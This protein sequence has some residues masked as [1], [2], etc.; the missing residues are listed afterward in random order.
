M[1]FEKVLLTLV[2]WKSHGT[3]YKFC[4]KK[5]QLINWRARGPQ[6]QLLRWSQRTIPLSSLSISLSPLFLPSSSLHPTVVAI[7]CTRVCVWVCINPVLITFSD[8]LTLAW[9][10]PDEACLSFHYSSHHFCMWNIIFLFFNTG[11]QESA[12]VYCH[13]YRGILRQLLYVMHVNITAHFPFSI[14]CCQ[15]VM[16]K[17]FV[18]L[19]SHLRSW[20]VSANMLIF[21]VIVLK[22]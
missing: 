15:L 20:Q 13:E 17:Y 9:T 6:V 16:F 8:T 19:H 21:S 10:N 22:M 12:I 5:N 3:P 2:S 18:A 4:I 11:K 7:W 1:N 14:P